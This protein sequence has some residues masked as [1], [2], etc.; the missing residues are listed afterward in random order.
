MAVSMAISDAIDKVEVPGIS[1]HLHIC[2]VRFGEV[3]IGT[4]DRIPLTPG[5]PSRQMPTV[6]ESWDEWGVWKVEHG[7]ASELALGI[8]PIEATVEAAT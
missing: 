1:P 3:G 5:V 7:V 8:S 4:N 6:V 2:S